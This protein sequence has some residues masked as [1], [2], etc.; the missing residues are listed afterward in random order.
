MDTLWEMLAWTKLKASRP[1]SPLPSISHSFSST[2]TAV[3]A[4][5]DKTTA[6]KDRWTRLT[7]L[8]KGW[9]PAPPSTPLSHQE[10]KKYLP[11]KRRSKAVEMGWYMGTPA[12]S[13]HGKKRKKMDKTNTPVGYIQACQHYI[14]TVAEIWREW[15]KGKNIW[16]IMAPN[17][18]NLMKTMNHTNPRSW[19]NCTM[20]N[21]NWCTP[22]HIKN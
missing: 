12:R 6:Q 8:E 11:R 10:A 19:M 1:S 9:P 16:K 13:H 4:K 20:I 14:M 17:S 21:A 2:L 22:R 3:K 7:G 15:R 18:P 5:P